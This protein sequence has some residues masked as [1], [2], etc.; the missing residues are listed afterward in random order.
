M[1]VAP[2]AE[3][4]KADLP[5]FPGCR[6][7]RISRAEIR[8]Y[9]GRIEFWDADTEI[10]MVCEPTSY[11]HE[12]PGERLARLATLISAV[13]GAQID[14]AGSS[15]LLLRN[16]QGEWQRIMQADQVLF[17]RPLETVPQGLAIEVGL[18]TLPD[19]VLEVDNTTD[20]RRR[21]LG[22][23]ES[24]GFPEVWVEVP[25][26]PAPSRPASLRPGLTIH[27]QAE[28]GFR[29]AQSSRAFPGWTAE[30]IHKAL[31]ELELSGE[32]VAVLRRVGRAMGAA[33]GAGPEGDVFLRAERRD[34]QAEML[35]AN[36]AQV[37]ESRNIAVTPAISKSLAQVDGSWAKAVMQAALTCEN[38]EHFLHKLAAAAIIRQPPAPGAGGAG[39]P[40]NLPDRSRLRQ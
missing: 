35:R 4:R 19:V 40:E 12:M 3:P 10:A 34:S 5:D 18:D 13:R 29:T 24:W 20:V 33:E 9:E 28:G 8:S 31:N 2:R 39:G 16:E 14:A 17:L 23:Y 27:L 25:D 6:A 21:K 38:E 1:E 32:T 37:L 22:L 7:I 11:Y 26:H 36:A 15:D 30:E